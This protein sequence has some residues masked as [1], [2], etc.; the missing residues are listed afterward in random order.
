MLRSSL[1]A[2]AMFLVGCD[3][4]FYA[5]AKVSSVC[6]HLPGQRFTIPQELRD[7][8]AQ[9]PPEMRQNFQVER[10]FDFNVASQ[11]PAETSQ[12]LEARLAL[13]SVRLTVAEGQDL[14]IIEEAHLQLKPSQQSG[15]A[16]RQFDYVRSEAAPRTVSWN[17]DAFDLTAYLES[18]NLEYT[19]SL[20]GGLPEGDLVVDIDACVE[21]A[22]KVNYL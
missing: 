3:D 4:P 7:Q 6:Q 1:L 20:V 2:A 14:G 15:L 18:G 10:T 19:V 22:V 9:L 12:L 5:E 17:G 13:N 8:Y 16:A 21:A 11:L